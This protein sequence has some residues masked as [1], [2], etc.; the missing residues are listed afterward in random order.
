MKNYVIS[1]KTADARRMH[2][3]QEFGKQGVDFEFFDAVTP[4]QIPQLCQSLGIKLMENTHLTDGEKACFLSHV[5]LWQKMLD[6]DIGYMAIFEDD[7]YL[8]EN[9]H[10]FF[11]DDT[12]LYQHRLNLVKT[13]TFLQERKLGQCLGT[14]MD[15]R[16]LCLLNEQHF[17]AAGYILSK[18][19]AHALLELLKHLST[20][21]IKPIDVLIF[22]DLPNSNPD[23]LIHQLIPAICIQEFILKPTNITMPSNLEAMRAVQ[24]KNR[25]KRSLWQKIQ[26]EFSNIF[27]RTVGKLIRT[28]IEFR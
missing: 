27:R 26:G 4:S 19:T 21:Q 2:I 11:N 28:K 5:S 18:K 17:G 1:L 12:W 10:K 16:K 20:K 25:P 15:N 3:T 22:E 8:G 24:R 13:E 14:I 6:D 7:I 23:I 9:A